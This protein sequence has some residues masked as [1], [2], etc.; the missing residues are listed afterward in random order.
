MSALEPKWNDQP[1]EPVTDPV[2]SSK[3]KRPSALL[4]Y[5]QRNFDRFAKPINCT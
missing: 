3:G 1:A 4:D 2:T 5:A